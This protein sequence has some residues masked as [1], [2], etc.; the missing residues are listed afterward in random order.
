MPPRRKGNFFAQGTDDTAADQATTSSALLDD[1]ARMRDLAP[2][3]QPQQ[4]SLQD[5]PEDHIEPNPFQARK[6]F[7]GIEEL[8]QAIREHGFVSRLRVRP[9]P[10][11][12]DRFQLVYGERRLRAARAAGLTMIPCEVVA[13][14]DADMIEIGLA[15]NIQRQDLDPLEE[16]D[17]FKT[18]IDERNYSIRTLAKRIGKDKSYVEDRLALLRTPEDVQQMVAE[19]PNSLR[20]AREIAKVET[21]AARQP[22]IAGVVSGELSTAAVRE[23]VAETIAPRARPAAARPATADAA[24]A[25]ERDARAIQAIL[26]RWQS[27]AGRDEAAKL[28]ISQ[29]TEHV[30]KLIQA[31]IETLEQ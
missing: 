6:N 18:F 8:A 21:E 5:I 26:D 25:V 11:R 9:V 20:A 17:A 14:T 23:R 2:L 1:D 30:L 24:A 28:A 27:L 7:A 13:H 4:I 29:H 16:A 19:R 12:D 31:L 22:L 15:E 3:S 10:G